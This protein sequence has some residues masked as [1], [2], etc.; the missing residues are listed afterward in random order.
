MAERKSLI[1]WFQENYK[2]YIKNW[3]D[4]E[5]EKANVYLNGE[6][7][8]IKESDTSLVLRVPTNEDNYYFKAVGPGSKY[9]VSLSRLLH[10]ENPKKTV[11]VL[12][13][14]ETEGWQLMKELKGQT[15]RTLKDKKVWQK[16][17]SEYAEFQISQIGNVEKFLQIGVPNRRISILKEEINQNI[18]Q[19]CETGLS[20]EETK[21]VMALLPTLMD[22][23]DEM[24]SII[25][26]S[27]EHGDLHTN[28]IMVVENNVVFFDWGDA[29]VSHPFFSTRIFWNTLYD[30]ISLE[31]EWLEMV[32][33][34]RPYYLE[35]WTK[36]APM[37]EIDRALRI[38]DELA[39]V[40]RALGWHL[41]ITPYREDKADSYNKPAQ[42]LQVLLEH[43]A[44]LGK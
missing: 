17:I 12:G 24:E 9:E 35:P 29:S 7:E 14:N 6:I 4:K 44:L 33:E 38:S 11:E 8:H 22:M 27:I 3:I 34:F 25:P 30:L 1:P 32:E 20:K 36:I 40:Y 19:M 37:K 28:N 18:V 31:S 16:A 13:I 10:M 2:D 23:C 26:A 5:L 42:W 41:Y 39:C 15:L 21:S 43:R